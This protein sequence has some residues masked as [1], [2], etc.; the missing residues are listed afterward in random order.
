MEDYHIPDS[1]I[2]STS[3]WNSYHSYRG[4]LFLSTQA[5]MGERTDRNSFLQITVGITDHVITAVAT[6]ADQINKM[7]VVKFQL[8]FSSDGLHWFDYSEDGEVRVKI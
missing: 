4:R 6:Q 3:K 8:S 1:S 7:A 2:L 5:W